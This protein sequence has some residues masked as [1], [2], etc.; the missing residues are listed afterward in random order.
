M[1]GLWEYPN[2]LAPAPCPVEART[3][4]PGPTG[5]HIFTHMEWRMT[6]TAV[7]AAGPALPEGWVWAGREELRERYAYTGC[8]GPH[9]R[10]QTG[11]RPA[12]PPRA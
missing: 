6:S 2:E 3:L 4:E 9:G 11:P 7:E 10:P 5:K 1:A 8:S 12:G